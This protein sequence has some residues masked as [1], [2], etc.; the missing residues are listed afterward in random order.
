MEAGS[1]CLFPGKYV[2]ATSTHGNCGKAHIAFAVQQCHRM[3]KDSEM[4]V[5]WSLVKE[6]AAKLVE[7]AGFQELFARKHRL[8]DVR[9][10][11]GRLDDDKKDVINFGT[12]SIPAHVI[13]QNT[14]VRDQSKHTFV[15]IKNAFEKD[16]RKVITDHF[17][18]VL[19]FPNV[20][21][22]S[23]DF[24]VQSRIG[25][26]KMV[27]CG[28]RRYPYD[29]GLPLDL[30]VHAQQHPEVFQV[31]DIWARIGSRIAKWFPKASRKQVEIICARLATCGKIP[32]E[33]NWGIHNVGI[34][35]RYQSPTHVDNDVGP[36]VAC[37]IKC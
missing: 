33:H 18:D 12:W 30:Y 11:L 5:V 20:N 8:E 17:A 9:G 26:Q 37:A 15:Y 22:T 23:S 36:T 25:E 6:D 3:W 35:N 1:L 14:V 13:D 32:L 16:L 2:H 31:D 28:Y 27:M 24:R 21:R 7:I 10:H 29:T 34:S 4:E 19:K